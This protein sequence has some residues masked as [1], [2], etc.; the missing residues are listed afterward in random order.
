MSD[1]TDELAKCIDFDPIVVRIKM[2]I[3]ILELRRERLDEE[4]K[5]LKIKLRQAEKREKST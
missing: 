4:I 5:E 3:S 2:D 1:A